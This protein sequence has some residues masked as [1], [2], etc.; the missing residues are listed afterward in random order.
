VGITFRAVFTFFKTLL[1]LPAR[2]L[3]WKKSA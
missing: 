3:G 1:F 2:L